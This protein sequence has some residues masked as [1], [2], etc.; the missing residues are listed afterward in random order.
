MDNIWDGI[1]QSKTL[2]PKFAQIRHELADA[3]KAYDWTRTSEILSA[4]PQ[5]AN[6]SRP[7]GISLFTPLHQAAYGGASV[8]IVRQIVEFGAWRTLQNADG[9][10]P[11]DIAK[12][13]AHQHLISVLMPEY[14]HH[15]SSGAL[16]KI[17]QYFHQVIR[18]R[19]NQLVEEHAL[20]L[21]EL[22]PLLELEQPKMWFAVPGM[23][24]GFSY[25]LETEAEESRLITESWCRVVG[26]SGE[27]HE[28]NAFGSHLVDKGFV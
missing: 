21:P 4:H 16:S 12:R 2:D 14:K 24:G 23:Y 6:S 10:K 19:A 5:M 11:F 13:Q 8:E 25:R 9:E 3:A 28:I 26:G 27:R 17:Q 1:T 18:G 22:E 7:D 15:I 20:R